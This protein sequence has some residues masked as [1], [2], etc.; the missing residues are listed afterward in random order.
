M[1][2]AAGFHMCKPMVIDRCLHSLSQTLPVCV[3]RG[4]GIHTEGHQRINCGED[5]FF[6]EVH[7]NTGTINDNK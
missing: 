4:G 2:C 6:E 1:A 5:Y 3:Q 7:V